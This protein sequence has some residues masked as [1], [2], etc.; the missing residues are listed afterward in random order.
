M[1]IG[2]A[3]QPPLDRRFEMDWIS[4]EDNLPEV[5]QRVIGATPIDSDCWHIRI[6]H[7]RP[8]EDH[9]GIAVIETGNKGW[10]HI[11]HWMP[12]PPP[13]TSITTATPD[14]AKSSTSFIELKCHKCGAILDATLTQMPRG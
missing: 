9:G 7:F 2:A 13:P 11:S 5:G 12:L 1:D 8:P 3:F 14:V 6:G 4:V 10:H